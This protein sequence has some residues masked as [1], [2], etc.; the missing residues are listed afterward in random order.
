MN[1]KPFTR[2]IALEPAAPVIMLNP[3]SVIPSS[4]NFHSANGAGSNIS[5]WLNFVL[6]SSPK[7][8]G[9]P[10]ASAS[11]NSG[12]SGKVS[13]NLR[14][15]N[16]SVRISSSSSSPNPD[17]IQKYTWIRL[18]PATPPPINGKALKPPRVTV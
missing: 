4:V 10:L 9:A 13:L 3:N 12:L 18:W 16:P 7:R 11:A 1:S 14:S 8:Y 6:R 2:F 15:N 17:I 5:A